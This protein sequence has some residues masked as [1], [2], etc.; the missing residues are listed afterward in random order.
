MQFYERE[1]ANLLKLRNIK[2]I[3]QILDE[4]KVRVAMHEIRID[5]IFEYCPLDLLKIIK[6]LQIRFQLAEVKTF[7]REILL[8]V[9]AMHKNQVS[10]FATQSMNPL[11]QCV[12]HLLFTNN[13]LN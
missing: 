1:K 5:L 13:V 4:K 8:G 3:M 6:N 2:N 10:Y 7:M 12:R 11:N 9:H